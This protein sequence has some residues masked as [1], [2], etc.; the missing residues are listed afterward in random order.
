[1]NFNKLNSHSR[2]RD[3]RSDKVAMNVEVSYKGE[4]TEADIIDVS[5][6]GLRFV[7][8]HKFAKDEKVNISFE[9]EDDGAKLQLSLSAKILNDYGAAEDGRHS[10]GV[11]FSRFFSWYEM[12]LIEKIV[13]KNEKLPED[14]LE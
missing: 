8:P 6:T 7:S 4:L 11:K 9:V 13:W 5:R 14:D 1:M 2:R 3:K 10:Y 12:R